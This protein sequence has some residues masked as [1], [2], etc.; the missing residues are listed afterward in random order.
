MANLQGLKIPRGDRG[1]WPVLEYALID[2]VEAVLTEVENAR[3]GQG[4]LV[5]NLQ[6]KYAT[7]S[8]V[9]IA[10]GNPNPSVI[11]VTDLSFNA[12]DA[13]KTGYSLQI[14]GGVLQFSN[15]YKASVGTVSAPGYSFTGYTSTGF[16]LT[17]EVL[18]GNLNTLLNFGISGTRVGYF[19]YDTITGA[20]GFVL[21]GSVADI[22]LK[23]DGSITLQYI[24]APGNSTFGSITTS[25][26]LTANGSGTNKTYLEEALI[27]TGLS[28]VGNTTLGGT[29]NAG[30]LYVNNQLIASGTGTGQSV[31]GDA[32][33]QYKFTVTGTGVNASSFAEAAITKLSSTGTGASATSLAEANITTAGITKLTAT[34]TGANASSIAEANIA[35]A[36]ITKLTATG[37]GANATSIAEAAITKLSSTGTGGS[38]TSLAELNVGNINI[39][40]TIS[41]PLFITAN[42]TVAPTN[43]TQL[44]NYI[45]L[46]KN[47]FI[48]DDVIINIVLPAGGITLTADLDIGNAFGSNVR[49]IGNSMAIGDALRAGSRTI[50][51][52]GA[53]K[54]ACLSGIHITGSPSINRGI[55]ECAQGILY[56]KAPVNFTFVTPSSVGNY[57]SAIKV[58]DAGQL[59]FWSDD[60][61]SY[62]YLTVDS[63]LTSSY[64][65]YGIWCEQAYVYTYNT[66][67]TPPA[68]TLVFNNISTGYFINNGGEFN[69]TDSN[70]TMSMDVG[71]AA[72][73]APV[74]VGMFLLTNNSTATFQGS[75]IMINTNATTLKTSYIAL[76]LYM[77]SLYVGSTCYVSSR[78]LAPVLQI[79]YESTFQCKST[80]QVLYYAGLTASSNA[81]VE[82][83]VNSTLSI[84]GNLMID[85]VTTPAAGNRIGYGVLMTGNS[86]ATIGSININNIVRDAGVYV[87]GASDLS[88]QSASFVGLGGGASR[89]TYGA[90]VSKGSTLRFN[91]YGTVTGGSVSVTNC[92]TGLF[93]EKMSL[94]AYDTTPTYSGNGT[95]VSPNA[96]TVGNNNALITG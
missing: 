54:A 58:S 68:S 63:Q 48:S 81:A 6:D 76:L 59:H 1:D 8:Y 27:N 45:Q 39:T 38:A 14:V 32:T 2:Y 56:C 9:Q 10:I 30:I 62:N 96:G 16:Y 15:N 88:C 71:N 11:K 55:V 20:I 86:E 7:K 79:A 5:Q 26:K 51:V 67:L 46:Y 42:Q 80:V 90:R 83:T 4:S 23:N 25:G 3:E 61:A 33:V 77:S 60:T 13:S 66:T 12:G 75:I 52:T 24:T 65:A 64:Q 50:T 95:N 82:C 74:G 36:S 91:E 57:F 92:I 35:T 73:S 53:L 47:A 43:E 84:E 40:G 17:Q 37:T 69:S 70:L 44:R 85:A 28:V 34:G 31:F 89:I 19:K 21:D 87:S 22:E 93:A 41:S 72:N 94:I 78:S 49:I 18:S 29:T